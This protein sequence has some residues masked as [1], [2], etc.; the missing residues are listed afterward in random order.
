VGIRTARLT[1]D[2][3]IET[4]AYEAERLRQILDQK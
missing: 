1:R 2:R 3:I 4:P